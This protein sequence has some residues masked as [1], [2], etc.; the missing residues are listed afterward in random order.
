MLDAARRDVKAPKL[1]YWLLGAG[2]T[3]TLVA[4]ILAGWR[5]AC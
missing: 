1:A 2:I 5:S 4:N 3:V